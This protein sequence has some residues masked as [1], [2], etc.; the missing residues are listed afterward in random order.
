MRGLRA[1]SG[2]EDVIACRAL[3]R[4]GAGSARLFP[5]LAP[6]W[7]T[8]APVALPASLEVR[9]AA[10]APL[11]Q[12]TA[13]AERLRAMRRMSPTCASTRTC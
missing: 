2:R 1:E 9:L 5:D 13:L 11:A 8:R 4:P 12:V 10:D 7:T 3:T 6:L